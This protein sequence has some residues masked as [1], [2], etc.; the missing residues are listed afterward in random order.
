MTEEHSKAYES[1]GRR[2]EPKNVIKLALM[3]I[4]AIG[5]TVTLSVAFFSV[6]INR[7]VTELLIEKSFDFIKERSEDIN[8]SLGDIEKDLESLGKSKEIENV[9]TLTG[10]ERVNDL[11]K[12]LGEYVQT[13]DGVNHVY[14]GRNDGK[15][16]IYPNVQLPDSYD[17]TQRPWFKDTINT[18]GFNW[19]EPYF[20]IA[21]GKLIG[22][23]SIP[24]HMNEES[25]G[26]LA[27]DLDLTSIYEETMN[28]RFG[29][30]GYLVLL[31]ENGTTISHPNKDLIGKPI[32]I[33]ELNEAVA[34]SEMGY[35][36]YSWEDTEKIAMYSKVDRLNFKLLGLLRKEEF[37]SDITMILTNT[38]I[39]SLI[40]TILISLIFAI[41][42]NKLVGVDYDRKKRN[43]DL[44]TAS[45]QD[46][47]NAEKGELKEKLDRLRE[48]KSSGVITVEEYETKR[49]EIIKNYDI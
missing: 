42:S 7:T 39:I 22:T 9:L 1:N 28:M 37:T 24:V 33:N 19:S 35:M 21:T 41:I 5:I 13:H 30:S 18:E 36:I 47:R 40:S 10:D 49:A 4:I 3:F 17:P 43:N 8:I 20:D 16:Y 48:Y 38:I 15:M 25:V 45:T 2:K 23:L 44:K 14:L 6:Q 32:P 12:R 27:L 34:S 11:L 29:E 31:D 26:V 46:I